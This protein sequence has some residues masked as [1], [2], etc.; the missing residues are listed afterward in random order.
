MQM[1]ARVNRTFRGKEEALPAH[2]LVQAEV[3]PAPLNPSRGRAG[4]YRFHGA[5]GRC[6][7]HLLAS[8]PLTFLMT[9]VSLVDNR[10]A[11][12]SAPGPVEDTDVPCQVADAFRD[13]RRAGYAP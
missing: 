4:V 5:A 9:V 11:H 3:D 1:L 8:S 13:L 7:S 10:T 12:P 2:R 6:T